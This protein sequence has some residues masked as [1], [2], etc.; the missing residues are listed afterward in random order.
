MT[1]AAPSSNVGSMA[2]PAPTL[3]QE[4]LHHAGSEGT[5]T[6]GAGNGQVS[7][8]G[9]N[10]LMILD[11]TAFE[12]VIREDVGFQEQFYIFT[13]S[14]DG[15]ITD[16]R[17]DAQEFNLDADGIPIEVRLRVD[18]TAVG[19]LYLLIESHHSAGR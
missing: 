19:D 11:I 18:L 6:V 2:L 10:E 4:G 9:L 13:K 1:G 17:L 12:Y 8:I 14:L 3:V 5:V 7:A 15:L 16:V